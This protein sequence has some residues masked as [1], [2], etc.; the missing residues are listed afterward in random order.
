MK[1]YAGFQMFVALISL[2]FG[3]FGSYL[4]SLLS[5]ML[6]STSLTPVIQ[7]VGI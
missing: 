7:A 4:C 5:V 2:L 6:F 3:I 1:F